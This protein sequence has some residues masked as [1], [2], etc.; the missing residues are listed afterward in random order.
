MNQSREIKIPAPR[1][2]VYDR[3]GRVLASSRI[4]H[5]ISGPDDVL[6]TSELSRLWP[7]CCR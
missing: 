7:D 5:M 2:V 4:S 6:K 3:D 1:G